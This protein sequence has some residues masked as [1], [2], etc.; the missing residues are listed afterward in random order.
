MNQANKP[1]VLPKVDQFDLNFYWHIDQFRL[2]NKI[3]FIL[4]GST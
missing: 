4:D 3:L 1:T 2:I